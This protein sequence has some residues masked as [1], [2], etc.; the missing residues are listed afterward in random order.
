MIERIINVYGRRK[1]KK[2]KKKEKLVK[3]GSN[4]K[5]T[6]DRPIYRLNY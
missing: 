5:M 3:L 2:R 6:N 4:T 1:R